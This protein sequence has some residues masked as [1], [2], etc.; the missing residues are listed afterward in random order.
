MTST[1]TL[2]NAVVEMLRT[3]ARYRPAPKPLHIADVE[4]DFDFHAVLSGPDRE[5]TLLLVADVSST[6]V[7]AVERRV[8][9]LGVVI[10]RGGFSCPVTVVLVAEDEQDVNSSTLEQLCRV[11]V[12]RPAHSLE[13]SL[14]PLLPLNLPDA[15]VKATTAQSELLNAL[16]PLAEHP[17]T[18]DLLRAAAQSA[19]AVNEGLRAAIDRAARVI[20][21][22]V[23]T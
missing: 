2:A 10:S 1:E 22:E 4:F 13:R 7:V 23:D 11:L 6:P 20:V 19:E 15:A 9:A 5:Q 18:K 21:T 3:R 17:L 8:R 16:G 14:G 12:V